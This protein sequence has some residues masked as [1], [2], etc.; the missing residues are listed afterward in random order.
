MNVMGLVQLCG[1]AQDSGGYG[2]TFGIE[3]LVRGG[4]LK[5]VEQLEEVVKE[6]LEGAIG[7]A[8]GVASGVTFRAA[9]EGDFERIPEVCAVMSSR[10]PGEMRLASLQMGERLWVMSRGWGWAEGVHQQLDGMAVR[11][12]LH[13]AVAFGVLVSETTSSQVRAIAT[14]LYNTAKHIVMAAVR[15]IPL[16]EAVGLRV[17]SGVQGRIA[18]LA[19]E[20]AGK[21]MR[22]IGVIG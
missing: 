4:R 15:A 2:H 16:E 10:V 9:R 14:Y 7:P 19:A 3:G 11:N 5:T 20:C 18:E 13:H 22:D 17:L 1:A 21:G 8:D 6:V 12:D